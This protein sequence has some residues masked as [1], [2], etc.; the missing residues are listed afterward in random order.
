M[1][2]EYVPI[3]EGYGC[4]DFDH[5]NKMMKT[6]RLSVSEVSKRANVSRSTVR[7]VV[8]NPVYANPRLGTCY[9]VSKA[10]EELACEMQKAR[11]T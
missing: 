3:P 10:I 7:G 9:R 5:L 6:N 2:T 11:E 1:K 8:S 4:F